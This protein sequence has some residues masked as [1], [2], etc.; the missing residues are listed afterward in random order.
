VG[1]LGGASVSSSFNDRNVKGLIGR[2]A[3]PR[4]FGPGL[5]GI[6]NQRSGGGRSYEVLRDHDAGSIGTTLQA[7][8]NRYR[9]SHQSVKT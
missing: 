7:C 9:V 5:A 1:T 6:R 3:C 4:D 2:R 8:Y